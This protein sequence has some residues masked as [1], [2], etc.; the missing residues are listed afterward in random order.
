MN[1]KFKKT[2][3]LTRKNIFLYICNLKGT[4]FYVLTATIHVYIVENL[5]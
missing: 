1:E 2:E 5:H 4:I 3:K